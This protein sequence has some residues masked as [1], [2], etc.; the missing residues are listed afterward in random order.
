MQYTGLSEYSRNDPP[1]FVTVGKSD[2]IADWL[3]N[4]F[5]KLN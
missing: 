1:T 4:I 3:K 2:G 5:N